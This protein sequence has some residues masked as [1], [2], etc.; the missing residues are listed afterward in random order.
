MACSAFVDNK[1]VKRKPAAALIVW[2]GTHSLL[3]AS[4]AR[5]IP[6]GTYVL[7]GNEKSVEEIVRADVEK[8]PDLY[9]EELLPDYLAEFRRVNKIGSRKLA[10]GDELVF[11]ETA[12]LRSIDQ[13]RAAEKTD[14]EETRLQAR[15]EG[16]Y[17]YQQEYLPTWMLN[18]GERVFSGFDS[19]I[20]RELIRSAEELVDPDFTASMQLQSY[21]AEKLQIIIFERPTRPSQCY[22]A[23]F[24]LEEGGCTFY[25]LE[26][27]I[28]FLGAGAESILW[29]MEGDG[30]RVRLGPRSYTDPSAFVQE[31]EQTELSSGRGGSGRAIPQQS[32]ES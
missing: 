28:S 13:A 11:P 23:A 16:I 1:S 18:A 8:Y 31:L 3:W 10:P 9:Q 27:G 29:M 6:G 30:E 15:H 4:L 7:T 2:I 17:Q 22:F 21:P 20:P 12:V 32:E 25:T 26:K 5:A 19:G 14:K 24:R